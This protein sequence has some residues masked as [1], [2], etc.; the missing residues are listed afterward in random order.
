MLVCVCPYLEML[1]SICPYFKMLI[2]ICPNLEMLVC[3]C[4]YLEALICICP[5]SLQIIHRWLESQAAGG[6]DSCPLQVSYVSDSLRW[7]NTLDAVKQG[8][9]LR[10]SNLVTKMVDGV[11]EWLVGGAVIVCRPGSMAEGVA[12][13]ALVHFLCGRSASMC[14]CCLLC[15][16]PFDPTGPRCSYS[17]TEAAE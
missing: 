10:D 4:P 17:A 2:Y 15:G 12:H 7:E 6:L 1:I 3:V 8:A 14:W 13:L 16:G 9:R 11:V 5:Y